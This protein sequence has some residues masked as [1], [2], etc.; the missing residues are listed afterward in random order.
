MPEWK[1]HDKRST[2]V[3]LA[4]CLYYTIMSFNYFS[5]DGQTYTSPLEFI[6][7]I[8][9]LEYFEYLIGIFLTEPDP[10]IFYQDSAIVSVLRNRRVN[11]FLRY[12]FAS[13]S[14]EAW[15]ILPAEFY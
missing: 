5:N 6:A 7:V 1:N 4:H 8:E 14:Q 2:A 13:N 15:H 11:S 9:S 12:S 3:F 10:I